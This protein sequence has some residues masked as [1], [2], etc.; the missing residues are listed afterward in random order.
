[1]QCQFLN[2]CFMLKNKGLNCHISSYLQE[3][4]CLVHVICV[5]LRIVVSNTSCVGFLGVFSSSFVSNVASFSGLSFFVELLDSLTFIYASYLFLQI[6]VNLNIFFC[7]QKFLRNLEE[8][9]IENSKFS[10]NVY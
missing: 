5:C 6:W 2:A 7:V 8:F 9:K 1:M 3:V 4:T 10:Q